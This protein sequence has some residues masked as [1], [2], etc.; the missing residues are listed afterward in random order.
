MV[1]RL[2]NQDEGPLI[3]LPKTQQEINGMNIPNSIRRIYGQ[4]LKFI[5]TDHKFFPEGT[6]RGAWINGILHDVSL[7]RETS[8]EIIFSFY[9]ES[10]NTKELRTVEIKTDKGY[11]RI[12]A[13]E[14][15]IDRKDDQDSS[16]HIWTRINLRREMSIEQEVI[17][18]PVSIPDLDSKNKQVFNFNTKPFLNAEFYW[19]I[20]G[21]EN[22]IFSVG[23]ASEVVYS[24]DGVETDLATGK[25]TIKTKI[26]MLYL[27][28]ID[29]FFAE[30]IRKSINSEPIAL[31]LV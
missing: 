2:E 8:E 21:K 14:V 30:A 16:S 17:P 10:E 31:E 29:D 20:D 4:H 22:K 11:G 23:P 18:I 7:R 9:S 19:V 25:R 15:N 1:S 27:L 26:G 5:Q 24:A 6:K 12:E 28:P 3:F 13:I